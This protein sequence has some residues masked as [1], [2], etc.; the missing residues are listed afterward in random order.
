MPVIYDPTIK[1]PSLRPASRQRACARQVRCRRLAALCL[2]KPRR[3][4]LAGDPT[5]PAPRSGPLP[6]IDLCAYAAG[7]WLCGDGQG[8]SAQDRQRRWPR[9]PRVR[10]RPRFTS[11]EARSAGRKG[12]HVDQPEP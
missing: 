11:E 12:W 2:P 8:P 10:Q 5:L 6:M 7:P 1:S 9:R 3:A 4:W